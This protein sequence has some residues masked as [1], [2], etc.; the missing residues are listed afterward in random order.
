MSCTHDPTMPVIQ[1]GTVYVKYKQSFTYANHLSSTEIIRLKQ[2]I[3]ILQ[4]KIMSSN[5]VHKSFSSQLDL[6][7]RLTSERLCGG[8]TWWQHRQSPLGHPGSPSA[9]PNC[10]KTQFIPANQPM[11]LQVSLKSNEF[12]NEK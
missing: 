11:Q 2:K 8:N 1:A 4:W 6:Q 12:L 10:V 7:G 9:P 3:S 5:Q